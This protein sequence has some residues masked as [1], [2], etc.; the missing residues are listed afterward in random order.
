MGRQNKRSSICCG[1]LGLAFLLS[2]CGSGSGAATQQPPPAA[3]STATP[4]STPVAT[5]V[6]TPTGTPA[7][8]PTTDTTEPAP[9][10]WVTYTTSD[11]SL[12]FDHPAG[13]TVADAPEPPPAGVSIAI[14]DATGRQLAT[15]Q[16]NLVTGAVCPAEL[17]HAQ[18]DT[19]PLPALSQGTATPRFVFEGRTDPTVA[20]PVA[21]TTLAYG[22]TSAP[23]PTGPGACPIAHF[24][25][26]PPSGAAFGGIYDP[27]LIYP[28]KPQHI[29]TPQA[30]METQEYQDIR[31]MI[32]SLR[33]AG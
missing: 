26:W 2:S 18:L 20:D 1:A 15:L 12:S 17:P 10:T 4:V 14:G 21:A 33:P 13:W 8:E 5:P 27:Y 25:S 29:D 31:A 32:T 7:A 23:E 16:T 6:T 9:G 19:E 11:G 30:Y 22:I 24:F 3:E 28:G